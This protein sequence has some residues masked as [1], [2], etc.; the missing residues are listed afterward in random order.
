M[1]TVAFD[2]QAL[3][4]RG[5]MCQEFAAEKSVVWHCLVSHPALQRR[6]TNR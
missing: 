2:A 3:Q 5:R 1:V 6:Q 4:M